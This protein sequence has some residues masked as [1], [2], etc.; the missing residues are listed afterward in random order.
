MNALGSK[1]DFP[2]LLAR[3]GRGSWVGRARE[4]AEANLLWQQASAGEGR[5]LGISGEP[6]VGKTRFVRELSPAAQS[7]G[8]WV[9][10]GECYAEGSAP[11][12]PLASII[13]GYFESP[14]QPAV[15]LG[16]EVLSNLAGLVPTLGQGFPDRISYPLPDSP[17][18]Q[19]RIFDGFLRFCAALSAQHPILLF[20][21]DAQWADNDTL[22]LLRSLAHQARRL[23]ILIVL[24]YRE[25]ELESA[26]SLKELLLDLNH[27]RLA[28][29]LS[30]APLDRAETADLLAAMFSKEVA[31]EFLAS[32]YTETEGNPFFI[33]EVCKTLIE[34]GQIAYREQGWHY[35]ALA[36]M[37]IPQTVRATIQARLHQLPQVTQDTLR[38]AA[39]LGREF[40]FQTLRQAAGLDEEALIQALESALQA[41]II[42]EIQSVP[43]APARFAFVH[44][45]IPT[46][47]RESIIHVRRQRL[48][49]QAAQ[50][51]QIVHPDD[52]EALAYHFTE[53]GEL[54]QAGAYHRRA[55]DRAHQSAPAE[56]ARFY[57]AALE[58]WPPSDP[59]GQAEICAQ[60]GYCAWLL[61]DL[62]GAL[63]H[64]EDAFNRF[65]R[66]Q[67]LTQSGDMQ[68]M[69]GR[70]HWER[71]DH[72]LA[73]K[74]YFL[75][76][77]ILEQGPETPELARA[78]SAISQMYMVT[79]EDE[80]AI[81]WGQRALDMAQ[82]L[83]LE[84]VM[85]HA[86]D[87]IGCGYAQLGDFERGYPLMQDS[88]RRSIAARLP[89]DASRAY[90]GLAIQLQRQCRYADAREILLDMLTYGNEFYAKSHVHTAITRLM[91]I[92]WLTG[93]WRS[94]LDYRS[95]L[96]GFS[97]NVFTT[98]AERIFGLIDLDL[99]RSAAGLRVLEDSL[100][101]ALRIQDMQ[102]TV[103]HLGQLARA[104][105]LAGQD[106]KMSETLRRLL[107]T[108][109]GPGVH[110]AETITPLLIACQQSARR[111]ALTEPEVQTCLNLL[112][113]DVQR[114]QTAEAAAAL[115]ESL[116]CLA[117]KTAPQA[118]A[119]HFRTAAQGW[120]TLGR[121]HDQAR[122][123]SSLGSALAAL[124]DK[125]EARQA[126][127]QALRLYD[128]L[129]SQLDP[130]SQAA[131][132]N[133]PDQQAL[134]QSASD[135]APH[136]P[137]ARPAGDELT[138]REIEVLRL[139][140]QGLTNAQIADRLVVSPL[141][142]NAHL[143]S[144]F[145]KLGVAS[146]TAA[147]RIA[148]ERGWG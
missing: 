132:L 130:E 15:D 115:A 34:T 146:R 39:I 82:R 38:M 51:I 90:L 140:A 45:L 88:L 2:A 95:Q 52:F 116:G 32:V 75:A 47:L 56:A 60:L 129:A 64:Y 37:K 28:A 127:A 59:A 117:E 97:S 131:F 61:V 126:R 43:G 107:A 121:P 77:A 109:S 49:L 99:G 18:A 103:P 70:L 91:W 24:T 10:S 96:V 89:Y 36:K 85:V 68:R 133:T 21:D 81:V 112:T 74:H 104:Y 3:I 105:A 11:Y 16:D 30:L 102:T 5:V 136:L 80:Q 86:L 93:R 83:G 69:I 57:R 128:E 119:Q 124:G 71:A 6:G 48:H 123:L 12:A 54:T 120:E 111:S 113:G 8:A 1:D 84:E 134:R 7:S 23:P 100:P 118:A 14:S 66:L 40:D 145:N 62:P 142:V 108:L 147:A 42:L 63:S 19:P 72:E 41:Q 55:G 101:R 135:A 50:A 65:D 110:S 58:H 26:P 141:T 138:A 78:I 92:D 17:S 148:L 27:A 13:A 114:Y 79:G 73:L 29:H 44:V 67:A 125:P 31:P 22:S 4:M 137:A 25:A 53:G 122:A 106:A 76:Y 94:A 144:I 9:L 98:W 87:N 143:R 139:V 33:E 35:P 20:I 46:T